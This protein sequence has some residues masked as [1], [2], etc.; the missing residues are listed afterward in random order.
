MYWANLLHIYQPFGQQPDILEQIV[1]QSYRPLIEGTL[2]HD[3]ARYTL[4]VNGS[5]LELFDK[6]NYHDLIEGLSEAGRQGKI[7][8]TGSA[9]YHALLP[10]LSEREMLRQIQINDETCQHYLGDAYKPRG[11]FLPEMA[12]QSNVGPVIEQA[13]FE[14]IILDEIAYNG[15]T[16]AIDYNKLYKIENSSLH[17]FFRERR[18]SNVI[19]GAT[20]RDVE[21]LKETMTDDLASKRYVITAMDGETFGHHR[22]GLE[23]LLFEMFD[24]S[25]LGLIKMSDLLDKYKETREI[26]PLGC[27]WA[28]SE[29]EISQG[30]QFISWDDPKNEIH[31]LQRK[32]TDFTLAEFYKLPQT[33]PNWPSLRSQMDRALASD[34]FFWASAHPWWSIEM[35]EEGAAVMLDILQHL[36]NIHQKQLEQGELYYHQIVS[37]AFEW[38]RS[39]KILA[40]Q[41]HLGNTVRIPFKEQTLERPGWES[42][43]EAFISM[44]GELEQKATKHRDY[45]EAIMWR[46]AVW[47]IENKSDMYDAINAI[48][49]L[50]TK[51]PHDYVENTLDQFQK[52]YAEAYRRIRGGQPEQ[53]GGQ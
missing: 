17:V 46:D 5:L 20:V 3:G 21:R 45:E 36:S 25:S 18:L 12:Y 28:S 50:R 37:M 10:F 49:L 8:F 48:D 24:D 29:K 16:E 30:I 6:Y 39:G 7:E 43:Y 47:K 14:W 15:K 40:A 31:Q 26:E 1:R 23:Q 33:D 22:P 11:F 13:G 34:Q 4:N 35:I 53:R 52:Q 44:M 27:T 51:L 41:T 42:A 9:K 32:L 2:K 38:K 19:M